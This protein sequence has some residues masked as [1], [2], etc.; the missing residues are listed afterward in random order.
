[1]ARESQ[2]LQVLLIIFVMLS[3]VLGVTTYLYVK[4][5][6]E[7]GKA[8]AAANAAKQDADRAKDEM[9]KERDDLKTWIGLPTLST[10]EIH[11]QF[12]ED[13]ATYGN[14][15]AE[16]DKAVFG[17]DTLYYSRL[18]AS[19]YK[20]IQDRNFEL[21]KSRDMFN[22]LKKNYESLE[23]RIDDKL[24]AYTK[25]FDD[26]KSEVLKT[27]DA[28]SG[29]L[30]DSKDT[31]DDV[32]KRIKDIQT[33]AE[34][35]MN[36]EKTAADAS[37]KAA[38]QER[39]R[40]NEVQKKLRQLERQEMDVPSGEITWVD[41]SQKLVWINRGKAD[42]LQRGT[43][44][45]VYSADSSVGASAVKKGTIEVVAIEGDHSSRARITDDKLADP[46]MARDK[47][48]TPL[49]SPG[50]QNH[51]AATG[52]M[53]LDGDGRNQLNVVLG[54]IREKGGVVDAWVDEQG[55]KQGQIT[56][57][58]RFIVVGDAPDKSSPEFKKNHAE[59]LGDAA[60]YQ[61]RQLTLADFKQQMDYQKSSSIEHFGCRC[62]VRPPL[63][64]PGRRPPHR[65]RRGN[66]ARSY[67]GKEVYQLKPD[68]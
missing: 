3:V 36:Q 22:D 6:D 64:R 48:F 14:A 1:M 24:V 32:T 56:G 21:A 4:K 47:I 23:A 33:K 12:S 40:A 11:K 63:A 30:K 59:I 52:V 65:R 50:Q 7:M 57:N 43:Q 5:A 15:K 35:E 54:M 41:L 46:I 68:A 44:F 25:N 38:D 9:Q 51:F 53:N 20:T 60:R 67:P 62:P 2:G 66:E 42:F 39:N 19:M 45:T 28:Y 27:A 49:W 58:T 31:V 29:G 13:M 16:G 55:K 18:L 8:T 17:P 37:R 10:E 34:T 61:V 26:L